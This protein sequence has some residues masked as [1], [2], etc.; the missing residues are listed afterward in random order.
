MKKFVLI[1]LISLSATR[2]CA[3]QLA[4][5]TNVLMDA[6]MMPNI[7]V[8]LGLGK[9]HF[10][11]RSVLGVHGYFMNKPWGKDVKAWGVQPE[12]RYFF[13]GRAM[14]RWFVGI[15]AHVAKYD[16][17]WSSKVYA[18]NAVGAGL[19]FGYV[20]NLTSRLNIDVHSGF[21]ALFYRQ[22]E[23]FEGDF[24]DTE[25][26]RSGNIVANS[27]GYTLLPTRIGVSLTYIIK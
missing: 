22:K 10:A 11:E 14:S 26:S 18:G 27:R 5:G 21:G 23:H 2:L 24:Y 25:Y 13:S 4:I 9:S 20:F 17:T 15:G 8:E 19:T 7:G 3:Q 1:I 16:V 6:L 12:L